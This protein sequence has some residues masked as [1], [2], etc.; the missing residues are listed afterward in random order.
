MHYDE[1]ATYAVLFFVLLICGYTDARYGKVRNVVTVPGMVLGLLINGIFGGWAGALSSLEGIGLAFGL[2]VVVSLL[3]R[4]MG[5]GDAKLLMAVGALVGPS[6]LLWTIVY[7]ALIGGILA[8]GVALATG[9]LRREVVGLVMSLAGRLTGAARLDYSN[10]DSLRI[11]YA[12]PLGLGAVV[13]VV[14]RGG[15]MPI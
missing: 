2:F 11:P 15:V 3:G 4:V 13:A 1:I 7:G 10:T 9:R 12:V 5:A 8:V 6:I 14:L